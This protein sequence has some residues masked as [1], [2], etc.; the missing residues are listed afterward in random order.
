MGSFVPLF[1]Q[2]ISFEQ[3]A[4]VSY[5]ACQWKEK[6][7]GLVPTPPFF[8]I[9]ILDRYTGVPVPSTGGFKAQNL[10]PSF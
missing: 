7:H 2:H 5:Q 9:L 6:A 1:I 8:F 10:F 4:C 3:L